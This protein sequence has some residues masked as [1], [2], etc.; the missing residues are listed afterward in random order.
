MGAGNYEIGGKRV[1]EA[2]FK[3]AVYGT[4]EKPK[5]APKITT[6]KKSSS[7]NNSSSSN[8]NNNSS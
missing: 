8:R 7:R 6:K 4:K 1:S 3:K 2:A 5:P